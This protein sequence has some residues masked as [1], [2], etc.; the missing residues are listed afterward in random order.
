MSEIIA[1]PVVSVIVNVYN[2]S[3]TLRETLDSIASQT[4]NDYEVIFWDDCSRDNSKSIIGE[5][6]QLNIKYFKTPGD[7]S[8]GLGQA[9]QMAL[10]VAAGEWVAF[11]D[12]D[13]LWTPDK[14]EL[15]ME[16]AKRQHDAG[17]IYGRTVRFFPDGK[18]VEYDHRHEYSMLPEG[19]VFHG[20]FYDSCYVAISSVL[21]RNSAIKE[22]PPVPD[23][24][25]TSPDYYLYLCL[26]SK[27]KVY[28]VQKVI[29]R[30]RMHG[31]NMSHVYGQKMQKEI[32]HLIDDWK[33][34]IDSRL[35][36]RRRRVHS[37][38][39]AL[40]MMRDKQTLISGMVKMM[41]EGSFL[42]L[43][44]RPFARSFRNIRR[45]VWTPIWKKETANV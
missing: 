25:M 39:L 30:Y 40:Q 11:V 10:N 42:Y 29:C 9:R 14:L 6:P 36:K 31:G 5:Y 22:F 45:L 8:A 24:I 1:T 37:T 23:Y 35:A 19:D 34:H 17:Y 28:A 32:L 12:Q 16:I 33:E 26:A 3:K 41:F 4:Y 2:G 43:F 27:F 18:E 13:D 38:L 15:Q 7:N 20:L 44:S 21:F